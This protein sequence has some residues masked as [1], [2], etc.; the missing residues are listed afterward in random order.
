MTETSE[1]SGKLLEV[2]EA[3]AARMHARPAILRL[4]AV[5]LAAIERLAEATDRLVCG[6]DQTY[7]AHRAKGGLWSL[8]EPRVQKGVEA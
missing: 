2:Q 7:V 1:L 3:I 4:T 8:R 6:N 5:E